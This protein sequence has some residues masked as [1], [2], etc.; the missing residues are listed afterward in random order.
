MD[1]KVKDPS[2]LFSAICTFGKNT[3]IDMALEEMSELTK[4]LLKYKRYSGTDETSQRLKDV[5]EEIADVY[6]MLAQ[7]EILFYS[8]PVFEGDKGLEDRI[9]QKLEKL[10]NTIEHMSEQQ[11]D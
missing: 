7:L 4:A 5:R 6:I 9:N 3:Q 1:I 10:K 2:I 8:G 11:E